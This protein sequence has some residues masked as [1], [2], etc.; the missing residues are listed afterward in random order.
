MSEDTYAMSRQ[1]VLAERKKSS[2]SAWLR[3][4]LQENVTNGIKGSCEVCHFFTVLLLVRVV[5][6][7]YNTTM[8]V[9]FEQVSYAV[10]RRISIAAYG[11]AQPTATGHVQPRLSQSSLLAVMYNA[12]LRY[13]RIF[14]LIQTTTRLW[15]RTGVGSCL[16]STCTA[17]YTGKQ[18]LIPRRTMQK[19]AHYGDLYVFLHPWR[20]Y[21]VPQ[22]IPHIK[23][24]VRANWLWKWWI[25]RFC[26]KDL[27]VS[28]HQN[29]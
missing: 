4:R 26:S 13:L 7:N 15:T 18:L 22:K 9:A 24:V 27:A 1:Q 14:C 10:S 19:S 20:R 17:P 28:D 29:I 12:F 8:L 16:W 21:A 3:N 5:H 6:R 11:T 25:F 23:H 2:Q